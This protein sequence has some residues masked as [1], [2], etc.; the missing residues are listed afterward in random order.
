M[1]IGLR[2][3]ALCSACISRKTEGKIGTQTIAFPCLAH[4]SLSG[5]ANPAALSDG[6]RPLRSEALFCL[7]LG[8]NKMKGEGH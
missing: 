6:R 2:H 1:N 8:T 7:I 3:L 4:V 5:L